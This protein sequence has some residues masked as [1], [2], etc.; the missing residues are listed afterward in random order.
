MNK[1][2]EVQLAAKMNA[3]RMVDSIETFR[4]FQ[5]QSGRIRC[6]TPITSTQIQESMIGIP[7]S[8][9]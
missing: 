4:H 3:K 1:Q 8:T 7:Y 6:F 5:S 9:C 2:K